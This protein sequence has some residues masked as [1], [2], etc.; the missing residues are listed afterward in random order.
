M[1]FF[2]KK[3]I[4]FD[5]VLRAIIILIAVNIGMVYLHM[6]YF[7]D[8]V[9]LYR[10]VPFSLLYGPLLYFSA[11]FLTNHK[12]SAKEA[13]LHCVPFILSF[14]FNL[15][16]LF[17]IKGESKEQAL[18]IFN[19]LFYAQMSFSLLAYSLWLLFSKR[20]ILISKLKLERWIFVFME[21][22]FLIVGVMNMVVLFSKMSVA[23]ESIAVY[24]LR[25][26]VYL[27]TF[28]FMTVILAYYLSRMKLDSNQIVASSGSG[29][30]RIADHLVEEVLSYK[31]SSLTDEQLIA[32]EKELVLK[33]K[34]DELFL[35]N[36]LSLG[37]LAERL[38][39]PKHHLTQVFGI[40]MKQ[41]F[42][43][44]INGLR[45][46][47]ACELLQQQQSET[48]LEELSMICGFNS[49]GAFN[50]QFKSLIKCTPSAYREQ[51]H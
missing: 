20:M 43:Q 31:S 37:M 7:E 32:Y 49:K 12:V 10:M 46:A 34:R 36:S 35:I 3:R 18:E 40:K 8:Q 47:H 27:F 14:I 48:T 9:W 6:E 13:G 5:G 15:I 30:S 28:L 38:K 1:T 19:N 26:V 50:R 51:Y 23:E 21:V 33:V 4:D 11:Q 45:V 29:V 24:F 25:L 16:Y 17:F 22:M 2:L 41:T 44:Y 39:I 42:Y